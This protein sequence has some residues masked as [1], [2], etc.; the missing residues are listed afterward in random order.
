[1]W[2]AAGYRYRTRLRVQQILKKRETDRKVRNSIHYKR[3][4]VEL[5]PESGNATSLGVIEARAL[6]NDFTPEGFRVFVPHPMRIG[7]EL[8][9][10]LDEPRRFYI[11]ARVVWCNSVPLT[12]RVLTQVPLMFR[13]GLQFIFRTEAERLAVQSYCAKVYSELLYFPPK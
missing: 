6:L 9:L 5:R 10:T 3:V 13:V 1:M 12:N 7:Q 4:R 2:Q 8:A 11:R